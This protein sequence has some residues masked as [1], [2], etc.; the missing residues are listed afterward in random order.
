MKRYDLKPQKRGLGMI[1]NQHFF[2]L[3]ND[4][5]IVYHDM[6]FSIMMESVYCYFDFRKEKP[7]SFIGQAEDKGRYERVE[8]HQI[9]KVSS[10]IV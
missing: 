8:F 2:G 6:T 7:M 10:S 3:G 1:Y 5:L 9:L 4:E